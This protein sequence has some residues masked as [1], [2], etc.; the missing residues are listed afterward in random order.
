MEDK[1]DSLILEYQKF[2]NDTLYDVWIYAEDLSDYIQ[3]DSIELGW[4]YMNEVYITT[5]PLF[6]AYELADLSKV[7]KALIND[8]NRFVKSTV[9]H[10]LTHKYMQQIGTEMRS[11]DKIRV[12]ETYQTNIRILI[13]HESYGRTFIEEGI[14]E[15]VSEMMGEIIPPKRPYIPKTVEDIMDK[16]NSYNV[17]YKYS[18]HVL[19]PFLDA[20]GF[21][22]AVKILLHNPPPSY[23]EILNPDL[24]FDRLVYPD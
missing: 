16:S 4:Y 1:R 11:L 21:K 23:L 8:S 7:Q 17:K 10:E 12:H 24:Y 6:V 14:C 5:S 13:S 19:K 20:R 15:Y 18:S 22:K 3:N 2:M 9:I